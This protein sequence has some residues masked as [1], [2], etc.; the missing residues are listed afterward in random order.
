MKLLKLKFLK[1]ITQCKC[2]AEWEWK[3]I[4]A[5]CL[6]GCFQK[7]KTTYCRFYHNCPLCFVAHIVPWYTS[8]YYRHSSDCCDR[9]WSGTHGS[10][11]CHWRLD[12]ASR[13]DRTGI[14][15]R[16]DGM[17]WRSEGAEAPGSTGADPLR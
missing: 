6:V 15:Y 11:L 13:P 10:G 16:C 17:F 5:K 4:S 9:C 8:S 7:R 14:R 12:G 3:S 2:L 1:K